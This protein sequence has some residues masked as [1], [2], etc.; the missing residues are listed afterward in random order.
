MCSKFPKLPSIAKCVAEWVDR[1]IDVAEEIAQR[2]E[3]LRY[4]TLE[5]RL[6]THAH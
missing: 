6:A 3:E 4:R 5:E 2:P 1:R